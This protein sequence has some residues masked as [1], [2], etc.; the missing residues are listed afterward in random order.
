MVQI[1]NPNTINMILRNLQL[2]MCLCITFGKKHMINVLCKSQ[3]LSLIPNAPGT[4]GWVFWRRFFGRK[5]KYPSKF[6]ECWTFLLWLVAVWCG[7]FG[8]EE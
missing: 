3:I 6:W 7:S 1:E 2:Q 5:G 8:C 4:E